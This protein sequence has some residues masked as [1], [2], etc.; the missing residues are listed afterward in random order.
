MI[1]F[2]P[3]IQGSG[4][5]SLVYVL[6]KLGFNYHNLLGHQVREELVLK[7]IQKSGNHLIYTGF[8]FEAKEGEPGAFITLD[9]AIEWVTRYSDKIITSIRD[10]LKIL[11]SDASLP[12]CRP[13]KHSVEQLL[14]YADWST[15]FNMFFFPVDIDKNFAIS[16]RGVYQKRLRLLTNLVEYLSIEVNADVLKSLASDWPWL[17][18]LESRHDANIRVR[19]KPRQEA[20]NFLLDN[21][22]VLVPFLKEIGYRNISWW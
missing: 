7:S 3:A 14:V 22:D 16:G 12:D 21:C 10:P 20:V 18:K 17:N 6:R 8:H 13:I 19:K 15:K 4:S 9:K 1:L 11:E 5:N 2:F